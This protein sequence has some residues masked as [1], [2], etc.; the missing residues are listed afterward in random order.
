MFNARI[1]FLFTQVCLEGEISHK[2]A[3][4]S[5]QMGRLPSGDQIPW[6]FC[7]EFE[8]TDFPNFSGVRIVRIAVHP[9]TLGV[10]F[11]PPIFISC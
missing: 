7:E 4:Q 3:L 6:K 8:N 11:R 2:S 5:L 10:L 1:S 9:S